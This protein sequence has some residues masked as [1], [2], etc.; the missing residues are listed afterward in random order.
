MNGHVLQS[1][2]AGWLSGAAAGIGVTALVMTW[3]SRRPDL[4]RRLPFQ[5]RL[6]ILGIVVVN[7]MAFGLTLIGLVLGA[8]YHSTSIEADGGRF[9]LVLAGVLFAI[10]GLFA[11]VRGRV[12]GGGVPLV[13][14]VLAVCGLAF[15]VMMPWLAG[16]DA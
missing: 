6:P 5:A 13:L 7:A 3:L 15:G 11:F 8:V 16:I 4:A 9:R 2:L 14:G 1:L 12:R 10:G